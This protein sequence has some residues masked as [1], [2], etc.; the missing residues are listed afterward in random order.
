MIHRYFIV[1]HTYSNIINARVCLFVCPSNH[2]VKTYVNFLYRHSWGAGECDIGYFLFSCR[3]SKI[4]IGE[5]HPSLFVQNNFNRSSVA[6]R[7]EGEGGAR[8]RGAGRGRGPGRGR[9]GPGRGGRR[10]MPSRP[11]HHSINDDLGECVKTHHVTKAFPIR[12]R[13]KSNQV[14]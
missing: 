7:G 4:S 9:G 6:G 2:V 5:I 14:A 11:V 13:E 1:G 12:H 8:G 3:I 10:G